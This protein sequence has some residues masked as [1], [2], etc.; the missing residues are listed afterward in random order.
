LGRLCD[1]RIGEELEVAEEGVFRLGDDVEV[2]GLIDVG[3]MI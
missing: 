2:W 1:H 3:A